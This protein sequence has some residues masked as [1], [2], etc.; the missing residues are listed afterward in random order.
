MVA[1]VIIFFPCPR[2]QHR[3]IERLHGCTSIVAEYAGYRKSFVIQDPAWQTL[4]LLIL[5]ENQAA[6]LAA[7]PALCALVK[8]GVAADWGIQPPKMFCL[9]L[10]AALL[11]AS[12]GDMVFPPH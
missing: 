7:R 8:Q 12:S 10:D 3:L 5:W 1:H 4:L 6:Y 2:Q 9:A 11:P